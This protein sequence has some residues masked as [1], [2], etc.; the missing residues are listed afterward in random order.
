MGYLIEVS[1]KV[2]NNNKI[3]EIETYLMKIIEKNGGEL[4]DTQIEIEGHRHQIDIYNKIYVIYV[5]KEVGNL[6]N[7]IR[8][9]KQSLFLKIDSIQDEETNEI[10]FTNYSNNHLRV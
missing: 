3:K 8:K 9:L 2:L 1:L 5:S 10:I 4:K 6:E 7:L